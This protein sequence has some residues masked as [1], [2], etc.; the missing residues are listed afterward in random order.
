MTSVLKMRLFEEL[1]TQSAPSGGCNAVA[2]LFAATM[3]VRMLFFKAIMELGEGH[4]SR[5]S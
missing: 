5:P 1:Q 2:V 4:R 3:V